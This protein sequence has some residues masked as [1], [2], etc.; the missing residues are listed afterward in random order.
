M[1][2]RWIDL[3]EG[4]VHASVFSM[5][6]AERALIRTITVN[7]ATLCVYG[8]RAARVEDAK[9]DFVQALWALVV[10]VRSGDIMRHREDEWIGRVLWSRIASCIRHW[11]EEDQEILKNHRKRIFKRVSKRRQRKHKSKTRVFSRMDYCTTCSGPE[12]NPRV[13]LV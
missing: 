12:P 6:T 2:V 8:E 10:R 7:H 1:P 13:R 11:S 5:S 9:E 4:R 3:V